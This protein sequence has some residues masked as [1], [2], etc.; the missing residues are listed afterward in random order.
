M[1]ISADAMGNNHVVAVFK[2]AVH[3]VLE[4]LPRY[5]KHASSLNMQATKKIVSIFIEKVYN[6][7]IYFCF[8]NWPTFLT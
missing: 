4:L 6:F 1:L 8:I 5:E 7:E 2:V 3:P